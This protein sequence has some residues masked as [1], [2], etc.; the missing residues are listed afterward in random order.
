MFDFVI[1]GGKNNDVMSACYSQ[2]YN[3]HKL[4]SWLD[5]KEKDVYLSIVSFLLR[6]KKKDNSLS[7]GH[8]TSN[9]LEKR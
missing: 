1:I 2:S 7:I 4:K 3:S 5:S 6:L 8:K 9:S